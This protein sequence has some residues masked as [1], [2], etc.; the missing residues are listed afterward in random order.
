MLS[1]SST[2]TMRLRPSVSSRVV[3]LRDRWQLCPYPRRNLFRTFLERGY[4]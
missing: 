4:E 3:K 2:P 1:V